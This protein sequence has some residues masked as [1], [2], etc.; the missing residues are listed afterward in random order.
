[1]S[2]VVC[3]PTNINE[4]K[5]VHFLIGMGNTHPDFRKQESGLAF[6]TYL[7]ETLDTEAITDTHDNE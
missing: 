7:V 1:M 5:H 3:A 6:T 4:Q 2:C